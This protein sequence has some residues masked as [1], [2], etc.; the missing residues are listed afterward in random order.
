MTLRF[1][2]PGPPVPKARARKGKGGKW[3][4]PK[5]TVD[6][7]RC[8][9]WCAVDA[10]NKA[11]HDIGPR[12]VLGAKK[13]NMKTVF[14]TRPVIMWC[15]MYFPDKRTRD[16]DNVIKSI[17]DGCKG[18]LWDDDR[19]VRGR[20]RGEVRGSVNPRVEVEISECQPPAK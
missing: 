13:E 7:E 19:H 16:S 3:Y 4:T 12:G 1:T 8:V 5:K 20:V 14:G 9:G 10:A 11:N 15:D 18:V 17:Q 6:Y 2:I